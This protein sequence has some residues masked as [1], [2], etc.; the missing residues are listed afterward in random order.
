MF[1]LAINTAPIHKQ[2]L[3]GIR[4]AIVTG[5]L[6]PGQKL[7]EADL[8]ASAGVSRTIVREALRQ[9]ETEGLITATRNKGAMVRSLSIDEAK[10]IYC[11]RAFLE[12]LAARLF[13]ERATP[14]HVDRL[15]VAVEATLEA[16]RTWDVKRILARRDAFYEALLAGVGSEVLAVTLRSLNA[17]IA[18]WRAVPLSH[19]GRSKKREKEVHNEL[20]QLLQAIRNRN[21]LAAETAARAHVEG[22]AA[23]V[24][25]LFE[26]ENIAQMQGEA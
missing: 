22:I 17:R 25:R 13:T 10:D 15:A 20:K 11:I 4:R 16:Y 19:P 9:L 23:E 18:H 1:N 24:M 14:A 12:G 8:S 5:E 26:K 3:E 21:A 7:K 2:L 6:K